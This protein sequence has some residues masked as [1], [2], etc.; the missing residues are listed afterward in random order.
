MRNEP[1]ILP[2]TINFPLLLFKYHK[3][4]ENGKEPLCSS[5]CSMS[6]FFLSDL[7]CSLSAFLLAGV[8]C[9]MSVQLPFTSAVNVIQPSY[10]LFFM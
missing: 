8:Y 5:F 4:K 6:A 3:T 9:N 1:P 7:F 2:M 10:P